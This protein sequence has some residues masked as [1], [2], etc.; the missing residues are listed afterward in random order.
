[1][2]E[3]ACCS[4][5]SAALEKAAV[6]NGVTAG[7]EKTAGATQ[8]SDAEAE[9]K[10]DERPQW[11]HR[12]IKET[13]ITIENNMKGLLDGISSRTDLAT[14]VDTF[15]RTWD[16]WTESQLFILDNARDIDVYG[17]LYSLQVMCRTLRLAAEDW[18]AEE[19][20]PQSKK[21]LDK[22]IWLDTRSRRLAEPVAEIIRRQSYSSYLPRRIEIMQDMLPYVDICYRDKLYE[23]ATPQTMPQ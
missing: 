17:N 4:A 11:E 20:T 9:K 18:H 21:T 7:A 12:Y 22:A 19:A 8:P 10:I 13:R 2:P 14:S 5:A 6:A 3:Q 23:G 1:M 16:K 15:V